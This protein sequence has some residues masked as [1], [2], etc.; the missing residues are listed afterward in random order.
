MASAAFLV[1]S[2][3]ADPKNAF[4]TLV[5]VALSYPVYFVTVAKN[6]EAPAEVAV[7][8]PTDLR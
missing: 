6:K 2:V 3:V 8:E 5:L 1:L 7:I 4:F